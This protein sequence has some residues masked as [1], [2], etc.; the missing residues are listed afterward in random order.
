MVADCLP[1]VA[2]TVPAIREYRGSHPKVPLKTSFWEERFMLRVAMRVVFFT[3]ALAALATALDDSQVDLLLRAT[4]L[5]ATGQN[6]AA[7]NLLRG[8][9]TRAGDDAVW[10]GS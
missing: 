9:L 5:Q 7:A 2:Q 8:E 6:V 3:G 10:R 1:T 4:E